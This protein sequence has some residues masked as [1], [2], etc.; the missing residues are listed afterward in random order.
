MVLGVQYKYQ[1]NGHIFKFVTDRYTKRKVPIRIASLSFQNQLTVNQF[2]KSFLG[3]KEQ[4]KP[5]SNF[6]AFI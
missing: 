5:I 6:Y 1:K 3:E 2:L 4:Y